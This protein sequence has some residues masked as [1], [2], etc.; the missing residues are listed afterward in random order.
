M[1]STDRIPWTLPSTSPWHYGS[2]DHLRSLQRGHALAE[3][4]SLAWCFLDALLSA[5]GAELPP[6][7]DYDGLTERGW[8]TLHQV[9]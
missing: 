6:L 1:D 9:N 5:Q 3:D 2:Q 4:E 8:Q 7:L